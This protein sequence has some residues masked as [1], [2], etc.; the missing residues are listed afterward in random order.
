MLVYLVAVAAVCIP[1]V[2]RLDSEVSRSQA[3]AARARSQTDVALEAAA[4]ALHGFSGHEVTLY[5]KRDRP[6][7]H[8][9][10][11]DIDYDGTPIAV[12]SDSDLGYTLGLEYRFAGSLGLDLRADVLKPLGDAWRISQRV[13]R[14]LSLAGGSFADMIRTVAASSPSGAT[15]R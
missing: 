3:T 15:S 1:L 2:I 9:A 11:V 5:E 14:T 13:E 4:W 7:G 6:G 10:T 12:T 8:S